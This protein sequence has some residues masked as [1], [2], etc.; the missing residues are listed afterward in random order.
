M[1]MLAG[2]RANVEWDL[3]KKIFEWRI[4]LDELLSGVIDDLVRVCVTEH[5]DNNMRPEW[6]GNLSR[7]TDSAMTRSY[8]IS[9]SGAS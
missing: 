8:C 4:P 3:E 2:I 7:L 9:P 5:R 1:P 6:V